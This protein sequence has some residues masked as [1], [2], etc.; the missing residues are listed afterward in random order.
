[1]TPVIETIDLTRSYWIGR[2]NQVDALRGVDLA[3][4]PGEFVAV[5]GPSGSGKSTLMNQLGALD[6][7]TCGRVLFDGRDIGRLSDGERTALRGREM[8]FIFQRYN[9]IPTLS[10]LENVLLA[11]RYAGGSGRDGLRAAQEML[12]A[13]GLADRRG[14]RPSELSGG[15]QQRVSIARALVNRPKLILA[16]EPTGNLD[17]ARAAEILGLLRR[18]NADF[19]Q[20]LVV[21]THDDEVGRSCDRIVRMRD[22]L[23]VSDGLIASDQLLAR[24]GDDDGSD[25]D[26]IAA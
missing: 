12:E 21:V 8:S 17:S 18:F 5:M 19:G 3:I 7:P 14:S 6:T 22:G 23:I 9:L 26:E 24:A 11:R 20:T 4:E 10:A 1:M 16:D 13:V 25:E 15:E 2:P